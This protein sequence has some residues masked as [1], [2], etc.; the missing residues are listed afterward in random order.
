M[1]VDQIVEQVRCARREYAGQFGF[2]LHAMAA[3]LRKREQQHSARIVS[4]PSKPAKRR[5]T[6]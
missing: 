4:F 5:K 1:W 6:A 3:D 2:D